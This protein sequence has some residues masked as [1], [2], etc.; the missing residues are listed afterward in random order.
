MPPL[1]LP[2]REGYILINH[3]EYKEMV[4]PRQVKNRV[5]IEAASKMSWGRYIGMDGAYVTMDTFGASA[6]ANELFERFGF[7]VK[8]VICVTKSMLKPLE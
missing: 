6:P 2:A 1:N 5:A 8:N 4:L 7:T 3:I